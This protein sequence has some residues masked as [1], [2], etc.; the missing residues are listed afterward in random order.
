MAEARLR[1]L[2]TY[3]RFALTAD[4]H[5]LQVH[6]PLLRVLELGDPA[7]LQSATKAVECTCCKRV[8]RVTIARTRFERLQPSTT[9][10]PFLN[11]W[12][13]MAIPGLRKASY[14]RSELRLKHLDGL[15]LRDD[16]RLAPLQRLQLALH[17][18]KPCGISNVRGTLHA[19]WLCFDFEYLR[20]RESTA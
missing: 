18:P 16:I 2:L 1:P 6:L 3:G 4:S 11:K 12:I 5:L 14:R 15:L 7:G 20:A 8:V 19:A 13:L 9:S 10:V 17:R